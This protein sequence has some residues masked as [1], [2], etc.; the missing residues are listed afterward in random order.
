MNRLGEAR[1][2]V[3]AAIEVW[4]ELIPERMGDRIR[5]AIIKGSVLKKWD[6]IVDYVPIISDLD[7][8]IG[9][10][11]DQ[12]IFPL[13][14]DGFR[15]SLETTGLYEERFKELRPDH[16]HIPRPQIVKMESHREMWLPAPTDAVLSLFG[17]IQFRG[18]ETGEDCMK[19]DLAGLLELDA[20]LKRMPGRIIDRIGFEY[21]RIM[22]EMCYIV[23]PTPVRVLSQFT[24]SKEA[25]K[26][27]RTGI[28][29]G[30]EGE[31]L[32][33]LA[34]AYRSYY[35]KGWEA[36]ESGFAD[37]GV[38]RELIGLAYDVLWLSHGIAKA[39]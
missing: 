4:G 27:N 2:D 14:R 10:I 23:S 28:I 29:R 20:L 25:W 16:I 22:R 32:T 35:H 34:K 11:N 5:Y 8:H 12:P 21:F 13:D 9:T 15:Y 38:M 6:S 37:N 3:D 39:I 30:L 19:R 33:E 17:E 36:F 7:I 31:G 18:V 24:D 26:M 1:K